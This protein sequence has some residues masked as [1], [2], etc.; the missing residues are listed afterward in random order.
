MQGR[1]RNSASFALGMHGDKT[2]MVKFTMANV[3]RCFSTFTN[4]GVDS[5]GNR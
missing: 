4:R 3:A 5:Y 2:T 1:G